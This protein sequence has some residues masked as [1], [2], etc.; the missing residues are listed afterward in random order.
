ML[1]LTIK[2]IYLSASTNGGVFSTNLSL[3]KGLN[4]IRAENSSGKSTCV[5]SIAYGLGLEAI[6]GPSR[7]KPFPS[8]L[9][10]TIYKSKKDGTPYFVH[11]S[12]VQLVIENSSRTTAV[13]TRDIKGDADKVNVS[14]N[15][16]GKDYFLG[17]SGSVGSAKSERGFH[18]W[19]AE[20]IGW[21]LPEVVTFEGKVTILY[22]ECIFPLFFIEQKRGWSEI[23]ANT[24]TYYGI[25]NLKKS[26]VEFCLSIDTFEHDKKVALLSNKIEKAE[27]DWASIVERAES[28]ARFNLVELDNISELKKDGVKKSLDFFYAE[29]ETSL[30]LDDQINALTKLVKDLEKKTD[31]S[32]IDNEKINSQ[33]SIVRALRNQYENV[34]NDLQLTLSSASDID[35][36]LSV[37]KKDLDQ[38]QQLLRLQKV[39]SD[40]SL[41]LSTDKCPIC[42]SDLYDTLGNKT[43]KREPMSLKANIDFLKNQVDFFSSIEIRSAKEIG[44]LQDSIRLLN[45]RLE[46]ESNKLDE[47]RSDFEDV[48]GALKQSIREKVR[49]EIKLKDAIRL[50]KIRDEL[51]EMANYVYLSWATDSESLKILKNSSATSNKAVAVRKLESLIRANLVSF[52]FKESAI[53]S[54]SLSRQTLRPEQEGYDIV[55]ESSASDYIRIIWSYTLALLEMAAEDKNTNHGGFVVFDEPRQHEA[56]KF[57]FSN[58][59]HKASESFEKGG[60]VIFATS[61]DAEDLE[62]ACKDINVQTIYFHDYILSM[63][64]SSAEADPI[65]VK[66]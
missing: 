15:G 22:L 2:N 54:I 33:V 55:A 26:A 65:P 58:L 5:N 19:L 57:S 41:D 23:Q 32:K 12:L 42:E 14:I 37:L 20:F 45:S 43:S 13:V 25:K 40:I 46:L 24:P 51:N 1:G 56:S 48:N 53:S 16:E 21:S 63:D 31:G 30:S 60:Q 38:Y 49:S 34:C 10:E 29:N 36:K 39:G 8:S 9:Y 52:G 44:E 62:A 4:I 59:I 6:L 18:S 27:E 11:S 66:E 35:K 50:Q 17:S 61:L 47:L 64:E 28:I 3:N 7:K